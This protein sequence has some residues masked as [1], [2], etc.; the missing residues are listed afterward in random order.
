MKLLLHFFCVAILSAA[1]TASPVS[2]QT[3]GPACNADHE[4]SARKAARSLI[5][6]LTG[7]FNNHPLQDDKGSNRLARIAVDPIRP[8]DFPVTNFASSTLHDTLDRA[9]L[10]EAGS[11]FRFSPRVDVEKI[12]RDKKLSRTLDDAIYSRNLVTAADVLILGT[13]EPVDN[14]FQ[15]SY[16][17]YDTSEGQPIARAETFRLNN[18]TVGIRDWDQPL[19][20]SAQQVAIELVAR[21]PNTRFS[22]SPVYSQ[23]NDPVEKV[24]LF[25]LSTYLTEQWKT[26]F[27][28]AQVVAGENTQPVPITLSV[29]Y[30]IINDNIFARFSTHPKSGPVINDV[31][32]SPISK[33]AG[34]PLL[35]SEAFQL[36]KQSSLIQ[37]QLDLANENLDKVNLVLRES[38]SKIRAQNKQIDDLKLKQTADA[39]IAEDLQHNIA[40]QVDEIQTRKRELVACKLELVDRI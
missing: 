20:S 26:S 35:G 9:M 5:D 17:A 29:T 28:G 2:A 34:L 21:D 38:D 23:Q 18:R 7:Y 32:I 13:L 30:D 25:Y 3:G 11:R 37:K 19:I 31:N 36:G 4:E 27:K 6:A 14:C 12:W 33:V 39:Q 16:V 40:Q 15:I 8:G 22:F 10:Q 24:L 1:L